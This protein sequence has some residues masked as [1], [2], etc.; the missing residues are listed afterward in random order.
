MNFKE[1]M[2]FALGGVGL[3]T[4]VIG[5]CSSFFIVDP[6]HRGVLVTMGSVSPRF[7]PE[8][9]GF[10]TPLITTV[11][12]IP[13]RQQTNQVSTECY[14]SDLQQVNVDLKVLYRIPEQS[15]VKMFQDYSGNVFDS[16][17]A[18]R[19][20]E[21]VKE[22]TALRSAEMIVKKREE[23]KNMTIASARHKVGNLLIIEDVVIE[24]ISLSTQLEHAIEAKMVQEQAAAQ[25]KFTQQQTEIEANTAVIKAKGEA[26]AIELRGRALRDNPALIQLQIVE[27]WDGHSPK[28]VGGGT[29]GGANILLPLGD[30][31]H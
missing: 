1:G 8:G 6:G 22:V 15:V 21:A 2:F 17:L 29:G 12:K 26:L 16:L 7:V 13:V 25:A 31:S 18:P 4:I 19:I 24:N 23:I 30:M 28:V 11:V 5:L 3:L 27:K 14:S 20:N 9:F 10:K